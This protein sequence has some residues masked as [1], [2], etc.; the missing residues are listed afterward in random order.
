MMGALLAVSDLHIGHRGNRDVV[1][2]ITPHSPDDWLIVA[3][4]VGEKM[5]DIVATLQLLRERVAKLIWV[6]GNHELWSL[7][8]DPVRLRGEDRYRH[9]VDLCRRLDIT[10]PEDDFPVWPGG[11]TAA[12]AVVA[13]LFL[14]YDYSFLPAGARDRAEGLALAE[15]HRAVA[16]DEH[17]LDPHPY[18]DVAQWS[19]ARVDYTVRRLATVDPKMPLVLVNHYPLRREPTRM[20]LRSEFSMWCG[21][22]RTE[23][24][25]RRYNVACAVYGHLHIR[26]TDYFDGVRF[27]EVS[28]GYP[29]EWQRRG[30]PDP[31]LRQILP[32]P[33]RPPVT[34]GGGRRAVTDLHRAVT[35]L[36]PFRAN[37][38]PAT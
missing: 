14:L 2:S 29:R 9:L 18:D 7:A 4:D 23:D 19:A 21:T 38:T 8:T 33:A 25:H 28:L 16:A 24:W 6:P 35:R 22:V 30:C 36:L 10:T 13:P 31:I 12:P 17:L 26:R 32:A 1:E 5:A 37:R 27:E 15:R 11:G 34:F 20:L 3:G